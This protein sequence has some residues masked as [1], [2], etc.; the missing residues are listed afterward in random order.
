MFSFFNIYHKSF[1]KTTIYIMKDD[2]FY[3]SSFK[4]ETRI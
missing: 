2:I 1:P 4:C 3:W